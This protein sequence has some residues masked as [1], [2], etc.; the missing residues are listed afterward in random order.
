M[1]LLVGDDAA[2][3]HEGEGVEGGLPADGPSLPALAGGVER[4]QGE[5][6]ALEGGLVG[7]K[8]PPDRSAR[9]NRALRDSTALVEKITRRT[10]TSKARKGTNSAQAFS[11]S[12]TIPG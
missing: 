8:C 4:P 3:G 10:S 9:R 6:E 7:G 1:G 5:V 2:F 12:R 11:Q